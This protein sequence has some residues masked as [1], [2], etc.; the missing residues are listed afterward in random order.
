PGP[1]TPVPPTTGASPAPQRIDQVRA[2]LDELS[3]YL[4]RHDGHDGHHGP[5]GHHDSGR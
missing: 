2:E 1:A 3:D 5:G 4:R